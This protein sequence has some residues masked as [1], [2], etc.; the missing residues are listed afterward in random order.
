MNH[1]IWNYDETSQHLN[2]IWSTH[3][4][5]SYP[6]QR[7]EVPSLYFRWTYLC[8]FQGRLGWKRS[9]LLINIRWF[10][11]LWRKKQLHS[12]G[13]PWFL[14]LLMFSSFLV[15][16]ESIGATR[17]Q[18]DGFIAQFTTSFAS[19]GCIFRNPRWVFWIAKPTF[20]K[21]WFRMRF[22][23]YLVLKEI[24]WIKTTRVHSI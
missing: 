10:W 4:K 20:L 1:K 19:V 13:F 5:C 16:I 21:C 23:H 8:W 12:I 18:V 2:T 24:R 14:K 7:K 15:G 9:F 3:F 11:R 22:R 6:K 17:F